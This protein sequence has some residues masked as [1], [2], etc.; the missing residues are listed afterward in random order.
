MSTTEIVIWVLVNFS[1][2][3]IFVSSKIG[4]LL[5]VPFLIP[6]TFLRE[7]IDKPEVKDTL[8]AQ[9]FRCVMCL[10]FWTAGFLSFV[11]A[12]PT[13]FFL[14]DMFFGSATAWIIYLFI[15]EKQDLT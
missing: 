9:L 1:I 4:P 11:W 10:S 14:W 12:S 3:N 7:F 2:A 8:T 6:E 13:G 5:S 15:M